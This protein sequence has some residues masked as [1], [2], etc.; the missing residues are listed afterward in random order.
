ME[1]ELAQD[2]QVKGSAMEM[3]DEHDVQEAVAQMSNPA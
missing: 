3:V 1:E 2:P